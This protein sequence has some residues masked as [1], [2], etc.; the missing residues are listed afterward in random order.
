MT[1]KKLDLLRSVRPL[2]TSD[3]RLPFAAVAT[4]MSMGLFMFSTLGGVI[5]DRF[6]KRRIIITLFLSHR[7]EPSERAAP[8][9]RTSVLADLRADTSH[10]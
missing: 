4:G 2:A 6:S 5:A 10:S 3:Y 7:E 8:E 1:E 9:V